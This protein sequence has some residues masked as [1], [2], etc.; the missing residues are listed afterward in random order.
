MQVLIVEDEP[1]SVELARA[2]LAHLGYAATVCTDGRQAVE[3]VVDRGA[4]F[5]LIVM[6]VV[7]PDMDGLEAT[8]RIRA[9]APAND[10][11]ILAVSA[12]VGARAIA[13]GL[14][15]GADVFLFKP[16]K[17]EQLIAA[18]A[19]ALGR[20]KP[21]AAGPKVLVVEDDPGCVALLRARLEALGRRAVVATSPEEAMAL[22]RDERPDLALIDLDLGHSMDDGLR[23]IR[24]LH[25]D[26]ATAGI[27]LAGL[28]PK[29]FRFQ[30][31]EALLG[32]VGRRAS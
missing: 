30:E 25:A 11:P 19:Q 14:D 7:L 18:V 22:A 29:P 1:D 2:I 17:A 31:L 28:L 15:A 16:Y 9:A 4:R 12:N 23:L 8:R 27:P 13:S 20:R 3:L 32:A 26:P 5:D 10:T 24:A 21:P 6:D